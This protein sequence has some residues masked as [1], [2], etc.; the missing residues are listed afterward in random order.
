MIKMNFNFKDD[1]LFEISWEVCNKVGGINTVINTKS[2][3]IMKY[4]DNYFMI[5]P[6]FEQDA[7]VFTTSE[8]PERFKEKIKILNSIGINIHF[9]T[10]AIPPSKPNVILIEYKNKAEIMNSVKTYLWE[11][12]QIDSL[13]SDWYDYDEVMLWSWVSGMVIEKLTEDINN[14]IFIQSHEWMATGAIFYLQKTKNPKFK[15]VFTTHAT[16]L[17]RALSSRNAD[18]KELMKTTNPLTEAKKINVHTK[19]LTEKAA[20][21]SADAFTTVS[22]ITANETKLLLN[23]KPDIIT[24]NGIDN[25]LSEDLN[26]LKIDALKNRMIIQDF[27][28]FFFS[29]SENLEFEDVS[30]Y[31]TSGRNEFHNKGID[32]YI[33]ALGKLNTILKKSES[34]IKLINLFLIP[35]GD[36][37]ILDRTQQIISNTFSPSTKTDKLSSPVSTHIVPEDNEIIKAFRNA[38]LNNANTDNIKVLLMPVYL[39]KTDNI[40]NMTYYEFSS[41]LDLGVFPSYYE[42]WGYT[43]LESINFGVPAITT[44]K[45][46]IGLFTKENFK[47][48]NKWMTILNR[49]NK[50]DNEITDELSTILYQQALK[51]PIEIIQEKD[52]I[53]EFSKKFDWD[54]FIINYLRA[55]EKAKNNNNNNN[56]K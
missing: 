46:G 26:K 31:F 10:A 20:A 56:N 54:D 48:T 22:D 44:D 2:P 34:K 11:K 28:A 16:M 45:A 12:Y 3:S 42:P 40:F 53:V 18:L 19:F 21:H 1:Y 43:P 27:L 4:F 29:D 15:T 9:G 52:Q 39:S 50:S 49:T 17:G 13:G 8:P 47:K 37:Q 51:S 7:N 24:Y 5:G 32:T 14:N 30:L 33:N 55:Y 25:K 35:I 6:Y 41:A 38:N 36:F 23:K